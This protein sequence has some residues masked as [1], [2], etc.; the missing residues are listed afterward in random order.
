MSWSGW[1]CCRSSVPGGAECSGGQDR[2]GGAR[3]RSPVP[4]VHRMRRPPVLAAALIAGLLPMLP[5]SAAPVSAAASAAEQR[6]A[7]EPVLVV[8]PVVPVGEPVEL[9]GLFPRA[10]EGRRV[11]VQQRR[12]GDWSV[13][14]RTRTASRG[15]FE[16]RLEESEQ[17]VHRYRAVVRLRDP[18]RPAGPHRLRVPGPGRPPRRPVRFAGQQGRADRV[19]AGPPALRRRHA[20]ARHEPPRG[21]RP[22]PAGAGEALVDPRARHRRAGGAAGARRRG[23]ARRLGAAGRA[24]P[25]HLAA[26]G[27]PDAVGAGLGTA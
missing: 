6:A 22:D 15:V 20:T 3:T 13:V 10:E 26:A 18:A 1:R 16:V 7:A 2:P 24:G 9:A 19:G 21:L 17:R 25:G 4:T 12:G 5:A 11:V 8:A 27:P 14:A 23:A